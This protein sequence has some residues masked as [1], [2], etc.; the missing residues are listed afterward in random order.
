MVVLKDYGDI[1][2]YRAYYRAQAGQGLPGF[3]GAPVMYGAG[4]GGIFRGLF[5]KAVPF[6]RQGLELIKPHV[7]TAVNN[8]AGDVVGRVMEK[9]KPQ[10]GS[11][12]TYLKRRSGVKRKASQQRWGPPVPLKRMAVWQTKDQKRRTV[13]K[14]AALKKKGEAKRN[15]RDIF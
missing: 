6:L 14:K 11:G 9:M 1:D 7:K 10:E 3:V 5:R 15:R 13:K 2:A 12:V 4:L 8:I